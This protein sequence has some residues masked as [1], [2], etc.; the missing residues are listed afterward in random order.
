MSAKV[1]ISTDLLE[2]VRLLLESLKG[3]PLDEPTQILCKALESEIKA[4]CEALERRKAFTEYK[5]A[6]HHTQKRENNRQ[7]YL[8][9]AE[10][11]KDWQ[12]KKEIHS[13]Q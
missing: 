11:H 1:Q 9:Q 3:Q 2:G 12:S 4:K 5:Q 10:I 7:A 8:S 6:R 13:S